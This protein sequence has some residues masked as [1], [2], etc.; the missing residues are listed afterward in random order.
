[1]P[2][3]RLWG[4]ALASWII[5]IISLRDFAL[6]HEL[7]LDSLPCP[8][9]PDGVVGGCGEARRARADSLS[10]AREGAASMAR[11]A[12]GSSS[13]SPLDGRRVAA[14]SIASRSP[15][16][17]VL[18]GTSPAKTRGAVCAGDV[19][20]VA[21]RRPG[22]DQ[23]RCRRSGGEEAG[24]VVGSTSVGVPA[25]RVGREELVATVTAMA[26]EMGAAAA[27]AALVAMWPAWLLPVHR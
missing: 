22:D 3:A 13:T 7:A 20:A 11:L 8:C 23:A 25:A 1:M 9:S 19:S 18:A 21:S 16:R 15:R 26:A 24:S 2:S 6:P 12:A 14:A 27:P 17:A 4:D 5:A 10:G